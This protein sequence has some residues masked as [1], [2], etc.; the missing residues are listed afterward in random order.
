[1]A[2]Y[3]LKVSFGS[4]AGGQSACAK[5]DYIGREGKYEKDAEELEHT[6]HGNMPEWA[7]SDPAKYWQAADEN[8][9]ANGRLYSEVQFALPQELSAGGRRAAASDF[10]EQLT[11]GE[12][13]PYT[14]AIHRGG[15]DGENPHAHLMFSERGHDGIERGAEQWFRRYNAKAPEQG[16]A[17]KSRASKAGDWL[18]KTRT[19]WERTA[20]RAL[21]QTGRVER[22][23]RRSLAELREEA[24]RAGNLQRAAELSREPNVHLGPERYRTLR[25]GASATVQQ[26]ARIERTNAADRGERDMDSRRVERLKREVGGIEARLKETYDRVRT[27]IDERIKQAGRAVRAGSEAVGRAGRALGRAGATV[28]RAAGVRSGG[29]HQVEQD[30]RGAGDTLSRAS[31]AIGRSSRI[32][33]EGVHL[34][35]RE[36]GRAAGEIERTCRKIDYCIQRTS[37]DFERGLKREKDRSRSRGWNISR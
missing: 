1:M 25:G 30:L 27:A 15:T 12:R 11:G 13:L 19:A 23:D 33:S 10:A 3:H 34:V 28:G 20:N 14:L 17:R 21:E 6:E 4:R 5:S 31:A 24:Y 9:R 2:V 22:I 32:R 35:D 7:R 29:V 36:H 16:G 8:E 37:P 26:A 18:D